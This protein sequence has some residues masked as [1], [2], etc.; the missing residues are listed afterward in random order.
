MSATRPSDEFSN[1]SNVNP[2]IN[3]LTEATAEDFQE[4]ATIL[5]NH[6]DILDLVYNE[7]YHAN[8]VGFF[9]NLALVA[10]TYPE[11]PEDSFAILIQNN[12][13][14][15][16]AVY[17]G[18]A[19][20]EQSNVG[21]INY[22][23]NRPAFP[24]TGQ[25]NVWY[26][27]L[28]SQKAYLWYNDD[29]QPY[30]SP[31]QDGQSAYELAVQYGYQ[32]TEEEWVALQASPSSL[33]E[34]IPVTNE[35]GGFSPGDTEPEGTTFTEMWKKLLTSI[36]YPTYLAPSANLTDNA[37][38]LQKIGETITFGLTMDFDRGKIAGKVVG[39]IW[40]PNTLQDYRSG[41]AT[42]YTINGAQPQPGNTLQVANYPVVQGDNEFSA[43]VS[44][45]A[46][47]PPKDSTGANFE[48]PLA[49]GTLNDTVKFE[50][51]HPLFATTAT[52]TTATEQ[53]LVSMVS[54]NNIELDLVAETGGSK[55]FFDIP[56]AWLNNRPLSKVEF[57]NPVSGSF[58]PTDQTATFT[59][60]DVQHGTVDY[61][62]Y[63]NITSDRGAI[64]L[65]LKF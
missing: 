14:Y 51:V 7:Q 26:I 43:S 2:S 30:G 46:G 58:D 57:Y 1:K 35:V 34:T 64:T 47:P 13:P 65:R 21:S 6:A 60:T 25:P 38:N 28:D 37:T 24:G 20:T 5:N 52:I 54:G 42:S 31:G 39:G 27:A 49:A 56:Q 19:W 23:A 18:G 55:Q 53:A 15:G 41:L 12:Q 4:A 8:F 44:Y 36:F 17:T 50:G 22:Y 40:Q 16:I 33:T 45:A 48:T 63:T 3:R 9:T 59:A 10:E 29:Y 62:R 61:K 32:G 11:P